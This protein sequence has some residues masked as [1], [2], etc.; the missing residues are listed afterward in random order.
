MRGTTLRAALSGLQSLARPARLAGMAR[1]AIPTDRALGISTPALKK[2]ARQIGPNHRLAVEL[3]ATGIHEARALAAMIEEPERSTERQIERWVRDFDGW[4]TCDGCC[5]NLIVR[6]PFAWR[7]AFEWSRRSREFEKRAGF[8]LAAVL[9]VHDQRAPD[10]KFL[11]FLQVL[12]R[13]AR[14]ERNFVKKAVNWALRQI[15]KR[16]LRLNRAA[17]RTAREIR[18][19]DSPAARWV[20]ADALRELASKAVKARLHRSRAT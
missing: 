19:L 6:L 15:G 4:S 7:K 10:E 8:A 1:F 14:D 13:H 12:K 5:L 17:L 11:R 9:A 18:R 3:W 16:N 2:L 20:A